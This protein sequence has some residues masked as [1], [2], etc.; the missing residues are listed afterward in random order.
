MKIDDVTASR[1]YSQCKAGTHLVRESKESS[2]RQ[3]AELLILGVPCI[4]D[5]GFL[6][7]KKSFGQVEI[8]SCVWIFSSSGSDFFGSF[9]LPVEEGAHAPTVLNSAIRHAIEQAKANQK[10]KEKLPSSTR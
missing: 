8:S 2:A 5:Y 10:F 1:L 3:E 7:S 6:S 4:I 9:Y